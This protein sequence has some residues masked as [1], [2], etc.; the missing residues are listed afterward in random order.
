MS[1]VH[2]LTL[3]RGE[4]RAVVSGPEEG[5]LVWVMPS[6]GMPVEIWNPV[7]VALNDAG[8]RV[9][10]FDWYGHG[11][12][13]WDRAPLNVEGLAEQGL[14]VL[15]QL[16]FKGAVHIVSM[17]S[18]DLVAL[19]T[20]VMEPGRVRSVTMLSPQGTAPSMSDWWL[21]WSNFPFVAS[22]LASSWFERHIS[23]LRAY[24]ASLGSET[25]ELLMESVSA[26]I[27]SISNNTGIGYAALSVFSNRPADDEVA[28]VVDGVREFGFPITAILNQDDN[29]GSSGIE[30]VLDR[31]EPI[32]RVRINIQNFIDL[33]TKRDEIVSVLDAVFTGAGPRT[34]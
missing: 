9:I 27:T 2:T 26:A 28:T 11:G 24:R 32:E 14:D 33:M 3:G 12:S 20:A 4:V 15:D 22:R 5:R 30:A 18:A 16:G 19:H 31:M 7:A 10:R 34:R 17:G 23:Q 29:E 6:I 8:Y 21:R 1:E 25:D 13:S